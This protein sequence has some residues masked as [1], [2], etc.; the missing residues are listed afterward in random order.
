[1]KRTASSRTSHEHSEQHPMPRRGRASNSGWSPKRNLV[2][3]ATDDD[4]DDGDE[5]GQRRRGADNRDDS[6]DEF[7]RE[8]VHCLSIIEEGLG[9]S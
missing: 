6:Y 9:K 2:R 3:L 4:S 5:D 8:P 1:M 7:L